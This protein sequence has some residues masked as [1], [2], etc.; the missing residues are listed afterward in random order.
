MKRASLTV[1]FFITFVSLSSLKTFAGV[2]IDHITL[3]VKDLDE[4]ATKLSRLG[5][6]LKK[7]HSYKSGLQKGLTTQAIRFASGQYLQLISFTKK[8]KN[9]EGQNLGELGKWYQRILNSTAGGATVVLKFDEEEEIEKAQTLLN[10]AGLSSKLSK[11]TGHD[12]LSFKTKGPYSNL[13]FIF[14]RNPPRIGPRLI[15]HKNKAIGI[16]QIRI[17]APGDPFEWAKMMKL[18]KASSVGLKFVETGRFQDPL[19]FVREVI[20]ESS[21]TPRNLKK[22][23]IGKTKFSF[24]SLK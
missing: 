22:F 16:H 8:N 14:Y 13:A 23:T 18:T 2:S 5:F 19:L 15:D 10:Q 1:I 3:I 9:G 4:S 24:K 6:T 7:P 11:M 20:L 12:W 17:N 21:N